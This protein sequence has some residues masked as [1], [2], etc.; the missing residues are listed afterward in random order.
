MN[1][2]IFDGKGYWVS[3]RRVDGRIIDIWSPRRSDAAVFHFRPVAEKIAAT[4]HQK[5]A[6][7]A[8]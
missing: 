2:V 7:K 1:T 8:V 4:I 3:R 6:L 5:V